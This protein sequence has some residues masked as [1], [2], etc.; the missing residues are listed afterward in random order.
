MIDA[1]SFIYPVG[2][3]I[4]SVVCHVDTAF[5]TTVGRQL[6]RIPASLPDTRQ[7]VLLWQKQLTGQWQREGARGG[8]RYNPTAWEGCMCWTEE[9]Q[10]MQWACPALK[11]LASSLALIHRGMGLP[12]HSD[13]WFTCGQSA[14]QDYL[15]SS[16]K[17]TQIQNA[18]GVC[19][20]GVIAGHVV[21]VFVIESTFVLQRTVDRHGLTLITA[22]FWNHSFQ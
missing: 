5:D 13:G 2:V 8:S 20:S 11:N 21:L 7:S 22:Q 17:F 15:L 18:R 4:L 9:L 19:A 12:S 6:N 14:W 16:V 10:T 3:D 1:T